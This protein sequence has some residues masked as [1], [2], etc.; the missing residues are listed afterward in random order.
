MYVAM[1]SVTV[2]I[3]CLNGP[4][5]C[6]TTAADPITTSGGKKAHVMYL[7]VSA[8]HHVLG[9]CLGLVLFGAY[10]YRENRFKSRS[11]QLSPISIL[12]RVLT[13]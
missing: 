11:E 4:S 8:I 7:F 12:S 10:I 13:P 6:N 5:T 2:V 1:N 9:I 3:P